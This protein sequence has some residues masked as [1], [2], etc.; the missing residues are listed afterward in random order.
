MSGMLSPIGIIAGP[1]AEHFG[2]PITE[3][4]AGFSWLTLGILVGA[5]I[6][7]II[8]DW[9]PLKRIMVSLYC[10]IFISL[11]SLTLHEDL[12]MIR[13]VLGVVGVCCGIGL[14]GAALTI[15]RTYHAERR[16]SMLVITD[17]SFSVAGIVCSMLATYLIA[18][19]LHWAS[20]Y[21]FVALV[22]A[23]VIALASLSAFPAT[24]AGDEVKTSA[25]ETTAPWP[26]T[27]WLC[28]VSLFLYTLGQYSI[29]LWIPNYAETALGVSRDLSGQIVSQYWMGMFAAQLFVSW[30]VFKIGVRKIVVLAASA[31]TIFTVPLW[32]FT[33]I[34]T[35]LI[36]AT[37][38]GFSNLA[39]L[40]VVL[41]FTT[42][43][44]TVPTPRLVAGILLGATMGTAVSPSITSQVV[45]M[46]DS[47]I[48]LL[49][50]TGCFALMTGLLVIATRLF[51]PN[52]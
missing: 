18:K 28:V 52:E 37:V 11:L 32:I 3:I 41:S 14:A 27:V 19:D 46:S 21:Q 6:A 38:W 22:A 44:V 8:F 34:D 10:L 15:S 4:T 30:W 23:M 2:L 13:V 31:C 25:N 17:S 50:G 51:Q 45:V 33:D 7:L 5:I 48:V 47:Y 35:L 24:S 1:M 36:M 40:K 20:T 42:Q 26:A 12:A 39:L 29:L 16:A 9:L 43:M 49:F